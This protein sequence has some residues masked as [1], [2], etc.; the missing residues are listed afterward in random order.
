MARSGVVDEIN[1][2]LAAYR[3]TQVQM[4]PALAAKTGAM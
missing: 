1:R 4:N 3:E 2:D